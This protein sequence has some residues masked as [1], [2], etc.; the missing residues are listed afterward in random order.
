MNHEL[1]SAPSD[2][3]KKFLILNLHVVMQ[4]YRQLLFYSLHYFTSSLKILDLMK[5]YSDSAL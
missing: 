2:K 1:R 4:G 5:V 3:L